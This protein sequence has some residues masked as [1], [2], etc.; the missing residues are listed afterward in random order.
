MSF[1]S[2]A[3]T[4]ILQKGSS[5][6][7]NRRDSFQHGGKCG[8]VAAGGRQQ[9]AQLPSAQGRAFDRRCGHSGRESLQQRESLTTVIPVLSLFVL[10]WTRAFISRTPLCPEVF[11]QVVVEISFHGIGMDNHGLG[12]AGR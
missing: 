5:P 10:L 1:L 11:I 2:L 12:V 3:E 7:V 4:S 9:V 8:R 6:R